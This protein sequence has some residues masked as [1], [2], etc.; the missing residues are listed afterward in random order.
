MKKVVI[1]GED[2]ISVNHLNKITKLDDNCDDYNDYYLNFLKDLQLSQVL[3]VFE[4]SKKLDD[5]NK[6]NN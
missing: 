6:D 3:D 1:K 2:P 4:E 5:S